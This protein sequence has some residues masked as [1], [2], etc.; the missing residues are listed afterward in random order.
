M[1][2]K[3][4][5]Y[6]IYK[7][8]KATLSNRLFRIKR[9][10]EERYELKMVDTTDQCTQ[11]LFNAIN[12]DQM[13][14]ERQIGFHFDTVE[15]DDEAHF[16]VRFRIHELPDWQFGL[17]WDSIK[18]TDQNTVRYCGELFAQYKETLDKFRPSRSPLCA[19]VTVSMRDNDVDFCEVYEASRL[20]TFMYNEFAL[21]FCRDYYWW[22][23]NIEHHTR[24]EAQ[25]Q[26]EHWRATYEND[27][28]YTEIANKMML[29]FCRENILPLWKGAEILDYRDRVYPQYEIVVPYDLNQDKVHAPGTHTDLDVLD[30][31][32]KQDEVCRQFVKEHQV[33]GWLRPIDCD[34]RLYKDRA[35]A[36][37]LMNALDIH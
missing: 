37:W 27:K 7:R 25:Q 1:S 21:A 8:A 24:E 28:K 12:Q 26:Y 17:W 18:K 20:L 13:E 33:T 35:E 14:F 10:R 2:K 23:Y 31:F 34:V 32:E 22:D 29:D 16:L 19:E 9:R 3:P 4:R 6:R 36:M 15:T 30:A 5:V 11:A